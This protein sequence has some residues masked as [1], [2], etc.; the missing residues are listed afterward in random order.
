MCAEMLENDKK[1]WCDLGLY[2][3]SLH[4]FVHREVI[5]LLYGSDEI[6]LRIY[7]CMLTNWREFQ[8][9]QQKSL[10]GWTSL[11]GRKKKAIYSED[12]GKRLCLLSQG[13]KDRH[14][15]IMLNKRKF[16]LQ[17]RKK[18]LLQC[19]IKEFSKVFGE[20]HLR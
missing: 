17:S 16:E 7:W 1:A 8:E 6:A 11:L 13:D 3:Q 14:D 10:R 12:K 4:S 2:V 15:G 18:F 9:Q 5:F 19:N 20:R